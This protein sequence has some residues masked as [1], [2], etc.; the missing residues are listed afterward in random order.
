M[1]TQ[2]RFSSLMVAGFLLLAPFSAI[3]QDAIGA[4]A[5]FP[6]T[7]YQKWIEM[8]K[9]EAN[10][11]IVYSSAGE[12][13]GGQNQ[14]LARE[15][16]FAVSGL[17]MPAEMRRN[18]NLVQFPVLIGAVVPIVNLPDVASG[19]V[20][21]DGAVLGRIFTGAI[22]TW[23]DPAIVALNPG[24]ALPA[25]EIRPVSIR[26]GGLGASFGFT[27]YI[28]AADASWRE[29]HGTIVTKRWAVGSTVGSAGDMIETVKTL[30][31]ALGYLPYGLASRARMTLVALRNPAGHFVT[32]SIDGIREAAANADWDGAKEL[33]MTLVNQPGAA[34]WPIAQTS[35]A[36]MARDPKEPARNQAARRFFDFAF[37]NG[38]TIMADFGFVPLPEAVRARVREVWAGLGS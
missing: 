17:P 22:K 5:S 28:L 33:V 35:Y 27:Q 19:Q 12:A 38:T 1:L 37:N 23:N 31:G 25:I 14:I 32:P 16:D 18:A 4:G 15:V 7:V 21:L 6:N 34:S 29:R 30:P 8:A 20:K 24:V 9:A 10:L 3:A 36:Q 13:A 2:K 26:D 11:S